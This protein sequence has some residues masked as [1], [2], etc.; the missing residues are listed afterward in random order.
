SFDDQITPFKKSGF[1]FFVCPGVNNWNRI[2]PQFGSASTNIQN[3]VRDGIKLGAIGMLNT[4]WDDDGE[5]FNAPNWYG[6][7]WGAECAWNASTTCS[8][9]FYRRMGGGLFGEKADA[10]GR[11]IEALSTPGIDGLPN[12]AF[13]QF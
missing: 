4:A 9:D 7:A 1:D 5:S 3:F 11:A 13:W 8:G 6:F 12:K 10:F 2:L